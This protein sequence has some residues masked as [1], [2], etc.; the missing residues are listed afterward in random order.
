MRFFFLFPPL[1]FLLFFF[2]F[3][4][5]KNHHLMS[6]SKTPSQKKYECEHSHNQNSKWGRP[7]SVESR[8][9]SCWEQTNHFNCQR[10]ALRAATCQPSIHW[11]HSWG[12]LGIQGRKQG[13][14]QTPNLNREGK[15]KRI[16]NLNSEGLK[17]T[18]SIRICNSD[19]D[20]TLIW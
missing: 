20:L 8:V 13:C 1:N 18:V 19:S 11:P 15:G 4:P 7:L 2:W 16:V 14:S 6:A 9:L 17:V 3:F 10:A 12:W 5:K